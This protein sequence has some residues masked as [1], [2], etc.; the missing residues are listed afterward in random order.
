MSKVIAYHKNGI[1]NLIMYTP[2]L[3]AIAQAYDTEIDVC[4]PE[5]QDGRREPC[6]EILRACPFVN[7]VV[8]EPT[9]SYDRWFY[10]EHTEYGKVFDIFANHQKRLLTSPNWLQ[11]GIHETEY[12]MRHARAFGYKGRTPRQYCPVKK[13]DT[14]MDSGRLK[15]GLCNGY[16][17]VDMWTRKA[18]P[19]FAELSYNLKNWFDCDIVKVGMPGELDNVECDYDFTGKLSITETAYAISQLDLFITTDTGNMHIGDALDVRMIALFGATLTSKNKPL[20]KNS[21]VLTA[22]LPCVP[23]QCHERFR[24]CRDYECMKKLYVGDIM[25][26]SRKILA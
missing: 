13:F 23:C 6:I 26:L 18:Y 21:H 5:W 19:H 12:Y 3:Q 17:K 8:D 9:K 20:S 4:V 14:G 11:M 7:E 25:N 22:G 16:F 24:K 2:A 1:G 10:T 15:I